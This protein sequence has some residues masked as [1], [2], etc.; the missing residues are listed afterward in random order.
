MCTTYVCFLA[1]LLAFESGWD[2]DRYN[3]G[4]IQDWQLTQWA[5]GP[6]ETYYPHH[7]SWSE[8]TDDEWKAMSYRSTNSLGFVGYQFGEALLIDL[9]YYQDD[10]YYGAG[11]ATNTWDGTWTGKRGI[12]SLDNFR[13]GEAQTFA[14]QEAFGYNLQILQN[15]LSVY[16][17]SLDNYIGTTRNYTEQGQTVSVELT[18]SGILAASHLRGAWGTASL[19]LTDTVSTDENGTSILQYIKQFGGYE[20]PG[21]AALIAFHDGKVVGDEGL[22]SLLLPGETT[23]SNG[24]AS[25]GGNSGGDTHPDE[26]PEARPQTPADI[27]FGEGSD[28][29]QLAYA[30]GSFQTVDG[31]DPTEDRIDFGSL[32]GADLLIE[33]TGEGLKVTVKNNGGAGYLLKDIHAADLSIA[34]NVAAALWNP[35]ITE[36]GGVADQL[37]GLGSRD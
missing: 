15:Q 2:R 35:V 26:D 33:D 28:T 12:G 11:S 27:V 34:N 21:I 3:A 14:I 32:P 37:R 23:G 29:I 31:F 17:K 25:D 20:T 5:G 18:L 10:V 36:A 1:A 13:T 4:I 8:L 6:V 24:A 7:A 22:G 19:L 16:G 30:W 9:G